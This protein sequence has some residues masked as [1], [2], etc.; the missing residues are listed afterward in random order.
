MASDDQ[1]TYAFDAAWQDER[2]RLAILEHYLDP[3]SQEV[4]EA[5][6]LSEGW[7]CLDAGAGGGSLTDWLCTRVGP[8][9]SVVALDRD[10]RFL[11]ALH[12]PNLQR[13]AG[14]L[15]DH[16]LPVATFDLVHARYLLEHIPERKQAL[17]NLT[18]AV[19]P[20]GLLMITDAGGAK[21]E[22]LQPDP[23]FE[24]VVRAFNATVGRTW[25]LEW[26]PHIADTVEA[27]GFEILRAEAF[28]K[29]EIGSRD[30]FTEIAWYAYTALRDVFVATGFVTAE[31]V[32]AVRRHLHDP[33]RSYLGF[34]TWTVV[35]RR[36]D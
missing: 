35:A 23:A 3:H 31:E 21:F 30:G 7:N 29:H 16:P 13:I 8:S 27:L 9:G 11:E 36:R 25:D 15:R 22:P 12:H 26:A 10:T 20:G 34:E 19:K 6:G 14:D 24:N 17:R 1:H 18:Q 28:R 2:A 5:A 32:D 33:S 4:L